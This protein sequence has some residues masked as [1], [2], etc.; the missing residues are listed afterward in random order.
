MAVGQEPG[1]ALTPRKAIPCSGAARGDAR[2]RILPCLWPGLCWVWLLRVPFWPAPQGFL[3][4]FAVDLA[5]P[6]PSLG[7]GV[8]PP[9]PAPCVWLP[10]EVLVKHGANAPQA[11][12]W[13]SFRAVG[14]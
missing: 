13:G 2:G 6:S 10:A 3:H 12:S 9:A 14:H 8:R 11:G 5:V 1:R 4:W 7:R